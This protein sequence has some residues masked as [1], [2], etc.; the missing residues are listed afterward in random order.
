MSDAAPNPSTDAADQEPVVIRT[1]RG[2]VVTVEVTNDLIAY[3]TIR[4]I[5]PSEAASELLQSKLADI[6]AS[7]RVAALGL[8]NRVGV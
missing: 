7:M 8:L 2:R 6:N 5:E 3:A 1:R 4:Q